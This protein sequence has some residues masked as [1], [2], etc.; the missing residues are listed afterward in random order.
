MR[1]STLHRLAILLRFLGANLGG[2]ALAS[3]AATLISIIMPWCFGWSRAQGVL[4]GTLLSFLFYVAAALWFFS[5]RNIA[6]AAMVALA[7]ISVSC[8]L[9]A[10]LLR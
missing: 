9:G 8:M 2:Y 1:S 10:G 3:L 7:A 4:L 5:V 6:V